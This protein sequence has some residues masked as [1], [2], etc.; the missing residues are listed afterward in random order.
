MIAEQ[1]A[2]LPRGDSQS[3]NKKKQQSSSS[4]ESSSIYATSCMSVQGPFITS[5]VEPTTGAYFPSSSSG[6]NIRDFSQLAGSESASEELSPEEEGAKKK[7]VFFFFS[8]FPIPSRF[9]FPER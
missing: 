7:K 3:S 1:R 5:G 6:T 4:S 9:I 8:F 2:R